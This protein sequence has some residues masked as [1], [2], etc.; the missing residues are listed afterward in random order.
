MKLITIIIA[1][2]FT[3]QVFSLFAS[4]NN[5]RSA[6]V[7]ANITYT[8]LNLLAP[9]TPVEATFEDAAMT[10]L[11]PFDIAALAPITPKEA[12]F[13]AE[14]DFNDFAAPEVDITALAPAL[15]AEA[16]FEDIP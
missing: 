7:N 4:G 1:A 14:A 12:D 16:D 6:S 13:E 8:E 11:T 9:V 3:L 10:F 15:P 5:T 2:V